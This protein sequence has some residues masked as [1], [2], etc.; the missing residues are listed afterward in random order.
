LKTSDITE[1]NTQIQRNSYQ[2]SMTFL[3][4]KEKKSSKIHMEDKRFKIS[5]AILSKTSNAEGINT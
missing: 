2:T 5:K 4:E 1:S 3:T